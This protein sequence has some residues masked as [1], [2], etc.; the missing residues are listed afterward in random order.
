MYLGEL[1]SEDAEL[2]ERSVLLQVR[3]QVF[4]LERLGDLSHKQFHGVRF[5][6]DRTRR[7]HGTTARE[8]LNH[9]HWS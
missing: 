1:V 3:S 7:F 2:L 6:L 4:L 8:I 9:G 5:F